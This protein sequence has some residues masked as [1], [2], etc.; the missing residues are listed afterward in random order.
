MTDVEKQA[1][2]E[3]NKHCLIKFDVK[4]AIEEI[5]NGQD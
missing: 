1:I 2:E 3:L 4:K 5:E